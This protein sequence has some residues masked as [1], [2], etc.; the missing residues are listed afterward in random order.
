MSDNDL[1]FAGWRWRQAHKAAPLW[2][3]E[4]VRLRLRFLGWR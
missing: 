3:D 2:A 1:L 4:R